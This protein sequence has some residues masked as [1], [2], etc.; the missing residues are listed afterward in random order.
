M[1]RKLDLTITLDITT[2][3]TTRFQVYIWT[4]WETWK[5]IPI[6]WYIFALGCIITNICRNNGKYKISQIENLQHFIGQIELRIVISFPWTLYNCCLLLNI[7]RLTISLKFLYTHWRCSNGVLVKE[8]R[9]LYMYLCRQ[10][11]E[12]DRHKK[13]I[14]NKHWQ[15]LFQAIHMTTNSLHNHTGG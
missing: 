7:I 10:N 3:T 11:Q 14:T 13:Y 9:S 5:T 8:N 2:K 12:K 1:Q 6:C 15:Q 4:L